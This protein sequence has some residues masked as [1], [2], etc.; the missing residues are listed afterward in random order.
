MGVW[1]QNGRIWSEQMLVTLERGIKGN[2]WFS[3]IDKVYAEETL[4]LAWAKV[5]SNDGAPSMDG[6]TVERFGPK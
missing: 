3:L 2:K 6:I 5:K 1:R 4:A